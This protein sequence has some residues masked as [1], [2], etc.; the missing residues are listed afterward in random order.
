MGSDFPVMEAAYLKFPEVRSLYSVFF[1]DANIWQVTAMIEVLRRAESFLEGK[2][3][4]SIVDRM[5]AA[6]FD[7]GVLRQRGNLEQDETLRSLA[8]Y[9]GMAFIRVNAEANR[10]GSGSAR[11]QASMQTIPEDEQ[12]VVEEPST[13]SMSGILPVRPARKSDEAFPS[14]PPTETTDSTL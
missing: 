8:S 2:P 6:I 3:Q 7:L 13:S 4:V 12:L 1:Q 9:A 5:G 14:P 11:E 10:G